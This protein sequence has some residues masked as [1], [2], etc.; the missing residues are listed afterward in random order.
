MFENIPFNS[1]LNERKNTFLGS[2]WVLPRPVSFLNSQG[3]VLPADLWVSRFL[4]VKVDFQNQ[5][6][7]HVLGLAGIELTFP[8]A[9]G[10]VLCFEC[11]YPT[12]VLVIAEEHWHSIKAGSSTPPCAH[13]GLQARGGHEVGRHSSDSWPKLSTYCMT[14]CS[15]MKAG[16]KYEEGD[17]C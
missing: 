12:T 11:W 16:E 10:R 5:E 7:R 1:Y 8:T 15:A 6:L 9:A 17:S 4:T 14:S 13:K 3:Y 2:S